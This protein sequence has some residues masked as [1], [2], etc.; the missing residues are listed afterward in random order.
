MV[1]SEA[2]ESYVQLRSNKN[3]YLASLWRKSST[4]QDTLQSLINVPTWITI[5]IGT[6]STKQSPYLPELFYLPENLNSTFLKNE[7]TADIPNLKFIA[8]IQTYLTKEA[9]LTQ[10]NK[11][12]KFAFLRIVIIIII[13]KKR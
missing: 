1:P 9:V 7:T 8:F 10:S 11:S 13:F 2:K 6:F 4:F 12:A 3:R 5:P